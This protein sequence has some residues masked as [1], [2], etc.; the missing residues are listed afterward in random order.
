[1]G[2]SDHLLLRL[3]NPTKLRTVPLDEA[4]ECLD[5]ADV[6]KGPCLVLREVIGHE[7]LLGG[8]GDLLKVRV[9]VANVSFENLLLLLGRLRQVRWLWTPWTQALLRS[10]NR[11]VLLL[12]LHEF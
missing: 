2:W 9:G 8:L 1:M 6:L 3:V 12:L 5:V 4:F 10:L 11:A 7:L